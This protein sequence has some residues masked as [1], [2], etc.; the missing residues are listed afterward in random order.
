ML[1]LRARLLRKQKCVESKGNASAQE[2]SGIINLLLIWFPVV[3]TCLCVCFWVGRLVKSGAWLT[4]RLSP[5]WVELQS[6]LR[7]LSA[8]LSACIW[9]RKRFC[10]AHFKRLLF[11]PCPLQLRG[12][13]SPMLRWSDDFEFGEVIWGWCWKRSSACAAAV[14]FCADGAVSGRE[15]SSSRGLIL[16]FYSVQLIMSLTCYQSRHWESGS[17][18]WASKIWYLFFISQFVS[19]RTHC[20]MV[21]NKNKQ[22]N[23][24]NSNIAWNCFLKHDRNIDFDSKPKD[25]R[26]NVFFSASSVFKIKC[27]HFSLASSSSL[28]NDLESNVMKLIAG[29]G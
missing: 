6:Y 27:R 17:Q 21:I 2:R 14:D 22:I 16:C 26:L 15:R 25:S 19:L 5:P 29:S 13:N 20:L 12:L 23:K 7:A 18:I 4:A 3:C 24:S 9:C 28:M 1:G 11:S 10:P 8:S